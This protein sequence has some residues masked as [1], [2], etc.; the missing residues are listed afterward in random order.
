LPPVANRPRGGN[1]KIWA[2]LCGTLV[3]IFG[4][5]SREEVVW[6]YNARRIDSA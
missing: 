3:F 4:V 5:S 1:L 6:P 2:D